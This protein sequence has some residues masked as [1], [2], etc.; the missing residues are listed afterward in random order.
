MLRELSSTKLRHMAQA[1]AKQIRD[2]TFTPANY[3]QGDFEKA[4][5]PQSDLAAFAQALV[6][7]A[8]AQAQGGVSIS[9]HRA[10]T[11]KGHLDQNTSGHLE[12]LLMLEMAASGIH[13]TRVCVTREYIGSLGEYADI[14][15]VGVD[16]GSR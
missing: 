13:A 5:L 11:F 16:I 7:Y 1:C 9:L 10:I 4:N 2:F 6:A 14:T 15:L 8:R 3:P 12:N